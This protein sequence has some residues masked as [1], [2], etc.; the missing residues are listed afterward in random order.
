MHEYIYNYGNVPVYLSWANNQV[1][2]IQPGDSVYIQPMISHSFAVKETTRPGHLAA[3]RIPGALTDS[4]IN[5]FSRYPRD[6]RARAIQEIDK[7]F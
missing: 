2:L 7:W 6:R 1:E 5:E 4:V 3:V